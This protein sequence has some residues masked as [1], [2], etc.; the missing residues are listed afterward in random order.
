M[1]YSSEQSKNRILTCAQKEFLKYGFE[2]ANLRRIAENAFVT[3]GALYNYYSGKDAL[4]DALVSDTAAEM[5]GQFRMQHEN[6]AKL[7]LQNSH[8]DWSKSVKDGS[9]WVIDYVFEHFPA[10]RLL[11]CCSGGTKWNSFLE[12]FIELEER[13]YKNYFQS[14]A[15]NKKLPS[16]FFF[17]CTAAA[18]FQFVAH[19]VEHDLSYEEA[20]RV[21][22]EEQTFRLAG[23]RELMGL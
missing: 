3:T 2:K 7:L 10:V 17:H 23:W 5:Y 21:M 20:M 11:L 9:Q 12:P 19:I 18:G 4:F 13:S 15:P 6:A 16:D 1:S 14:I 22:N 8:I